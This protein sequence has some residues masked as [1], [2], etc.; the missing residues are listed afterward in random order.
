MFLPHCL[1][2]THN[3]LYG[4]QNKHSVLVRVVVPGN[5]GPQGWNTSLMG[6]QSMSGHHVHIFTPKDNLEDP[7][8]FRRKPENPHG[9]HAKLCTFSNQSS[10]SNRRPRAMRRPCNK[11]LMFPLHYCIHYFATHL[12]TN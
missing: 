3:F 4:M 10:E 12:T 1:A 8:V 5:T 9:E 11:F 7:H 2:Q 6:M